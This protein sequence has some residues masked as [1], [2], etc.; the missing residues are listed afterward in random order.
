ME[1]LTQNEVN[2]LQIYACKVV[3]RINKKFFTLE[4]GNIASDSFC[5]DIQ[6]SQIRIYDG[7]SEDTFCKNSEQIDQWAAD[8]EQVYEQI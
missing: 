7:T 2:N 3:E 5:V 8:C 1:N 6:D 4:N